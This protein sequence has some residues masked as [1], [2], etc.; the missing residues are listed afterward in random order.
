MRYLLSAFKERTAERLVHG[1]EKNKKVTPFFVLGVSFLLFCSAGTPAKAET[2]SP[3]FRL[4]SVSRPE[5]LAPATFAADEVQEVT[6]AATEGKFF[7]ED[8]EGVEALAVFSFDATPTEVQTQ[9]E[10]LY[11]AGAVEVSAKPVSVSEEAEHIRG[12]VIKFVGGLSYRDIKPIVATSPFFSSEKKLKGGEKG[13]VAVEGEEAIE[14]RQVVRGG[15]EGSQIVLTATNVGDAGVGFEAATAGAPATIT[16]TLPAGLKA[17]SAEAGF[18]REP[19]VA[20]CHVLGERTV[21]CT[22]STGALA[23]FTELLE[24]VI[25]VGVQP[26]ATT[27]EVSEASISGGEGLS[28]VAVAAGTGRFAN[29]DC[30]SVRESEGLNWE[31]DATVP[32]PTAHVTHPIVIA[33][34]PGEATPYGVEDYEMTNEQVGG[35]ID[36]QAGSHPFQ[37]TVTLNL[38]DEL[39]DGAP[40]P[41]GLTKDLSFNLPPGYIGDPSAYPTCPLGEFSFNKCPPDTV[42][43]VASVTFHEPVVSGGLK[44]KLGTAATPIF[45]LEPNTGEPARFGIKPDE[46]PVFIDTSV[47]TGTDYGITA[48]VENVPQTIGFLANT[49]TFWGVPA[50]SAHDNLRGWGCLEEMSDRERPEKSCFPTEPTN[51]APF[52]SLPTSCTGPLLSTLETDPWEHPGAFTKPVVSEMPALDDCGALQFGSEIKL[53]PDVS[54]G[55]P[56]SGLTV[57]VHVPQE[58][59]L[60]SNG[61]APADVRNITVTLPEGLQL[62]PSAADGLDACTQAQVGLN[63]AEE[64]TCPNAAKIATAQITT[65]LLPKGQ[66][67][68]GFVYLASPQNFAG[69]PENPFSSLVAM[70]LVVRDPVSGVLVKLAGHV[71]L[72]ETGQITTTFQNN[73]QLPFE[74]AEIHFFGGERAPL[75]TPSRC[76][77]YTTTAGFE[78]WTNGGEVHEDLASSSTFEITSGPHGSPCPGQALPFTPTLSSETTDI[79]AGG[80][81]PLST[82]ISRPSGDQNIQSVTLHYPP[83]LTGSLSGVELCAEAQANAGTCGPNSQ[84][85][86][87]IVSVGVGGDPFTVTGGKAYITG[88]YEGAP[89]GLSIVNPAAAGPFD[90]QQGAPVVVRAKIEVNP[91]TAALTITTNGA[92]EGHSIPTIIEGFPLQI[93]HVN[94]LINRNNFTFNPTSCNKMDITGE[95]KSAEGASSPVSETFQVT[96]CEHLKF[97][98]KVSVST[99]GKTSKQDGA[100]LTYKIAYPK[101]PQ[102]TDAD[103][104]YVKVSLPSELPSRLTTLQK[105]CTQKVFQANPAGCP[106]ESVIGHAKAI[107]PNIPVPLE[108][109]V[110]FVSNGGEAFPNLVMVLQGYGVTIQLVG[111]TLIKNGVTSTTFNTVPDNPVTSFEINLPEGK[112]S[113]LAANGNLCK[114]T[115]TKTVKKKVWVQ[116]NGRMRTVTRKVKEQVSTSL[117]IPSDYIA[118][119]GATYNTNVPIAVTG[120]AKAHVTKKA[121]KTKGKGKKK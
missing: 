26:G 93:Q 12:Y 109:P 78:P 9:L 58:E 73:P 24:V 68:T 29:S 28:C 81:T 74:D 89:F 27:G 86:E 57:D 79:N 92:G 43:G 85:G 117:T 5:N 33:N 37:T 61:L 22:Y 51:P 20:Q 53:S 83:G 38:N 13:G 98:P 1:E 111:D 36:T 41:A 60:N 69:I 106:K 77:T 104:R 11:G 121:K 15:F 88:P 6:V 48:H 46:V 80:F 84:I 35:G 55:K 30:T 101:V 75:A 7:L 45:N 87:T 21:T 62:N 14:A 120:C 96:N 31:R 94:V 49:V 8:P 102:G 72:S 64:A 115:V 90:L 95:V 18:R 118:Q 25:D 52:L 116:I 113:A 100:S 76:G 105:A 4:S 71:T 91:I 107:V 108:G 34:T 66:N 70:Y 63:N 2:L 114:P 119:T 59:A 54:S 103:I 40:V 110:Y 23:P 56:P 19:G 39:E 47:R 50:E 10:G 44:S 112:F 3:W 65:P 42:V 82:T 97:E 67:L 17:L 32:A 99:S 16:D